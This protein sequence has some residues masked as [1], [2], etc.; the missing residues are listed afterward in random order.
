MPEGEGRR[1]RY[2]VLKMLLITHREKKVSAETIEKVV[3]TK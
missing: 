3:T 2:S 1:K